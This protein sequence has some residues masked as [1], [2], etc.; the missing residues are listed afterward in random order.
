MVWPR[1][2]DRGQRLSVAQAAFLDRCDSHGIVAAY[3]ACDGDHCALELCH[4]S[5]VMSNSP[6]NKGLSLPW[7]CVV[8]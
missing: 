8:L 3:G 4:P 5:C 1:K 2:T 7:R 6:V